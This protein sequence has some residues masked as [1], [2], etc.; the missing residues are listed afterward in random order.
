MYDE[1]AD[2]PRNPVTFCMI[3]LLLG[4]VG[5]ISIFVIENAIIGLIAGC[6]GMVFGG[7]SFSLAN[8]GPSDLKIK[9]MVIAGIGQVMSV[10]A[11]ML[12]LAAVFT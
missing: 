10:V 4:A 9:C 11:A 2:P 12:G 7:Y 5:V 6:I 3:A 1:Y 8:H